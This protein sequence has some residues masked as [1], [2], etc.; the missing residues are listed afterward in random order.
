MRDARIKAARTRPAGCQLAWVLDQIPGDVPV[1]LIGYS[2][3]ARVITGA[4]H[5][6]GGGHLNGMSLTERANPDRQPVRLVMIAAATHAHWLG[7]GQYHG[8]ALSQ[9]DQ[10]LSI[11]NSSDTI[12]RWYHLASPNSRPQAMGLCGPTCLGS[13]RHKVR[14]RNVARHVGSEH[15]IHRYLS[16]PGTARQLWQVA[17]WGE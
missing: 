12:M 5:L 13:E 2:F 1:G 16:S 14:V 17:A 8:Q 7:Q 9:V 4:L 3:G 6:L 15:D 10:A 11:N